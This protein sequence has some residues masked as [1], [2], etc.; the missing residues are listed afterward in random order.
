[1]CHKSEICPLCVVLAC[2]EFANSTAG[3]RNTSLSR[4]L[5][6]TRPLRTRSLQQSKGAVLNVNP[7]D[8]EKDFKEMQIYDKGQISGE[9]QLAYLF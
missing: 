2:V 1:M 3:S 4:M 7:E 6:N 9:F 8:V 5:Y